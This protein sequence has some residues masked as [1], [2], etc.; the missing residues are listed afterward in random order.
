MKYSLDNCIELVPGKSSESMSITKNGITFTPGLSVYF[1]NA[2][3]V[4]VFLSNN[5]DYCLIAPANK[6]DLNAVKISFSGG[7]YLRIR[8]AGIV[9]AISNA[10]SLD[11]KITWAKISGEYEEDD[12]M[13]AFD[14]TSTRLFPVK[15]KKN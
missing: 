2:T 9:L 15:T 13:I 4:K 6:K 11:T 10:I 7:K 14:L 3:H 8:D 5:K 1:K 12:Q